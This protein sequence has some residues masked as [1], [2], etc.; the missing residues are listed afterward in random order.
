M[1]LTDEAVVAM[2]D[3]DDDAMFIGPSQEDGVALS[4]A[5]PNPK[6]LGYIP[7]D[8]VYAMIQHCRKHDIKVV[9]VNPLGFQ[10]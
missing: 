3:P 4:W 5:E 9:I 6:Y 10:K 7:E 2:A 1:V 8:R